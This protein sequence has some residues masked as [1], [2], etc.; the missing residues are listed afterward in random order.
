MVS[1]SVDLGGYSVEVSENLT[2][3]AFNR[4]VNGDEDEYLSLQD[5]L[6]EQA[7]E[8]FDD[9]LS[10]YPEWDSWEWFVGGNC[11]ENALKE[12][13]K[14]IDFV[15]D[16][17]L[18]GEI[19]KEARRERMVE[20]SR[21]F[22]ISRRAPVRTRARSRRVRVHGR[23]VS[24]SFVTAGIDSGGGGDDGDGG[25]SDSDC[26]RIAAGRLARGSFGVAAALDGQ[27]QFDRINSIAT[28][29]RAW[30]APA[31]IPAGSRRCGR[32]FVPFGRWAA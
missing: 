15:I 3:S 13:T 32:F 1:V 10:S 22:H 21:R 9:S 7:K 11:K 31:D 12:I 5:A 27:G 14:G 26:N 23:H 25:Q 28:R 17:H 19:Q 6:L 8:Q 24:R 4:L 20:R 30:P 18:V 2:K 29:K 16:N